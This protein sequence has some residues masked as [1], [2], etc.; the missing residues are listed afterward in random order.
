MNAALDF[1]N[2]T[3]TAE[4]IE[5]TQMERVLTAIGKLTDSPAGERRAQLTDMEDS[6]V[7][8]GYVSTTLPYHRVS[9][10]G[11]DT[12]GAEYAIP[13]TKMRTGLE[14]FLYD[15][16]VARHKRLLLIAVPFHGLAEEFFLK[17]DR[18]LAGTRTLYHRLNITKIVIQLAA[19]SATSG[20]EA[21]V[22]LGITR[23]QLAW[24]D[25]DGPNKGLQV[26][27]L[28]GS[29]LRASPVYT[30]LIA[31]VLS[32][33]SDAHNVK[34]KPVLLGFSFQQSGVRRASAV[35]DTHGNFKVW[36]GSDSSRLQ[37]VLNLLEAVEHMQGIVA[38][39]P[40]IPILQARSIR[41]VE[42]D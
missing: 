40:N 33:D 11:V 35:T 22:A 20:A 5:A 31:P 12:L 32:S 7:A 23:C 36:L 24:S 10:Q 15:L 4:V 14:H 34:V 19:S 2:R 3:Y 29:D 25:R 21:S 17:V 9:R 27:R 18:V 38:A 37:R 13:R 26:V 1:A 16:V 39:T 41:D 6:A 8:H 28:V 42:A 30:S